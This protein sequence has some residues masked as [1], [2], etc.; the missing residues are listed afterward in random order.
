MSTKVDTYQERQEPVSGGVRW[1]CRTVGAMDGAIEPPRM[2]LR[3]VLQ[4]QPTPPSHVSWL[5]TLPLPLPLILRVPG[6]RP[7]PHTP[8]LRWNNACT[9]RRNA[10]WLSALL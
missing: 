6:R 1:G 10:A 8:Q 3:R 2:G 4:A 7:G 9:S 5:W